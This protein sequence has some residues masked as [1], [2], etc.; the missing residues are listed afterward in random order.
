MTVHEL[1]E[2]KL[3]LREKQRAQKEQRE[4]AKLSD[5]QKKIAEVAHALQCACFSIVSSTV[6]RGEPVVTGELKYEYGS[7]TMAVECKAV[8]RKDLD[9]DEL[10]V[11]AEGLAV[12]VD[13]SDREIIN[14][15]TNKIVDELVAKIEHEK[16]A[17]Q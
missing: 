3:A 1:I 17:K 8:H 7:T 13:L 11:F 6:A 5:L 14:Y 15:L 2:Q 12:K 10:Y 4:K 9:E 16:G